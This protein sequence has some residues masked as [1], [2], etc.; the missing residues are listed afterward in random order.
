LDGGSDHHMSTTYTGPHSTEKRVHISMPRA[1]FQTTMPGS[2]TVKTLCY[3]DSA[4]IATG[5]SYIFIFI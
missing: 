5:I 2:E 3:L 4:A 1:G